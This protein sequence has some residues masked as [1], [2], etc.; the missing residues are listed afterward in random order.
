M[1]STDPSRPR[2]LHRPIDDLMPAPKPKGIAP[3]ATPSWPGHEYGPTPMPKPQP[4]LPGMPGGVRRT[5]PELEALRD[6]AARQSRAGEHAQVRIEDDD[7]R[8]RRAA[9]AAHGVWTVA[10]WLL[11]ELPNAPISGE[12]LDY[13]YTVLEVGRE[14]THARDCLEGNDWP[15][16]DRDYAVGVKAAVAWAIWEWKDRPVPSAD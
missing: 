2:R 10:G 14:R 13:P 3:G 4:D 9:A 5:R 15:D 1:A 12:T 16:L 7:H 11:G 8:V 6:D